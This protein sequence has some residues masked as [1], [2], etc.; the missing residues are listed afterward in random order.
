MLYEMPKLCIGLEEPLECN[1]LFLTTPDRTFQGK[2]T[3]TTS[4]K[5]REDVTCKQKWVGYDV[6]VDCKYK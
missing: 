2:N 4:S 3:T 1:A 6:L 5:Y